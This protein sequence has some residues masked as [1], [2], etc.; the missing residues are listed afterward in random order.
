MFYENWVPFI[1]IYLYFTLMYQK[2]K[3]I[4][5]FWVYIYVCVYLSLVYK[6]FWHISVDVRSPQ[7]K[8]F[9]ITTQI[10]PKKLALR[11]K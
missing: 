4:L 11:N 1:C 7:T 6:T 2:I 10:L 3:Y 5:V 9:I 8:H